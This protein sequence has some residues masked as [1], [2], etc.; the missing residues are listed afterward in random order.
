[1]SCSHPD[2]GRYKGE[3]RPSHCGTCLPCTVRRAAVLRAGITD[4][5]VYRDPN[6]ASTEGKN[7]LNSYRYGIYLYKQNK[8]NPDLAVLRSGPLDNKNIDNYVGVYQRG[9][10]ELY[11][12]LKTL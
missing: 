5:S 1:M 12:F 4:A 2:L 6:F 10:E 11:A 3:K 9:M 7:F 8:I